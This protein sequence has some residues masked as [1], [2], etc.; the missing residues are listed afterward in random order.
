VVEKVF[1]SVGHV[2]FLDLLFK[3]YNTCLTVVVHDGVV[4]EVAELWMAIEYVVMISHQVECIL[5]NANDSFLWL[6]M[7]CIPI[8]EKCWEC[9]IQ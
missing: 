2:I 7:Y 4:M 1:N 3:Y 6:A 9:H 8:Q 5:V